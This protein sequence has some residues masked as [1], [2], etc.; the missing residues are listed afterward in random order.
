MAVIVCGVCNRQSRLAYGLAV[1]ASTGNVKCD[2][3]TYLLLYRL[4]DVAHADANRQIRHICAMAVGRP[5][6]HHRKSRRHRSSSVIPACCGPISPETVP[7][8]ARDAGEPRQTP[9]GSTQF[10]R[11]WP[12]PFWGT[13]LRCASVILLSAPIAD[14]GTRYGRRLRS[15]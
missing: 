1:L 8:S 10:A 13:L 14:V 4:P 9:H 15:R 7:V 12:R 5:L 2:G 3:V 6:E 11:L